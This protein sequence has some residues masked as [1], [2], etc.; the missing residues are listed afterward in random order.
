MLPERTALEIPL[1]ETGQHK[2]QL[3]VNFKKEKVFWGGGCH[4][5]PV[6]EVALSMGLWSKESVGVNRDRKLGGLT[7]STGC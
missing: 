5:N 1:T 7:L 3:L 2:G 6:N 4:V